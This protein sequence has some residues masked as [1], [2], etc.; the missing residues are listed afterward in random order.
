MKKK[1]YINFNLFNDDLLLPINLINWQLNNN[2]S[3]LDKKVM[4][5]DT[6]YPS[7]QYNKLTYYALFISYNLKNKFN[8]KGKKF[9][10]TEK[11]WKH[12]S[13]QL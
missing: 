1:K 9:Y 12:Y 3:L 11:S 2:K 4:C 10:F 7:K 5:R 8:L 6:F 13:K